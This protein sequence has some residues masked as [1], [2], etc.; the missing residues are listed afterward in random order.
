MPTEESSFT[1]EQPRSVFGTWLGVV[2]LFGVFGLFVWVVMAAAPRGDNYEAKR[3]AARL[4]KLKTAREEANTALHG[5]GWVDKEKG[6]ARI[7][8]R[9][10]MELTMADL[11][12]KKPV[13]ANPIPPEQ[14]AQGGIQATAPIAPPPAATPAAAPGASAPPVKAVTGPE[15]ENRAQPAGAANPPNAA[16]GTQ[17]GPVATPAASPPAPAS[18]PHPGSVAPEPTPVQD[19]PGTPLPVRGKQP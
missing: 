3:A 4:E 1:V 5:Y 9:R 11:A 10:A 6:V 17:P 2:L 8:V 15:S 19:S 14:P 16:P 18:Q 12:G 7:P 13:P